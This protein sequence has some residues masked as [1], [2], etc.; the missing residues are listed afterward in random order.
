MKITAK[1]DKDRGSEVL[2]KKLLRNAKDLSKPLEKILAIGLSSTDKNFEA[3]GRPR[4]W[5]ELAESTKKQRAK[6]GKTGKILE[7][8]N[9]LKNSINGRVEGS[10]V[11]IGTVVPY[12]PVHQNGMLIKTKKATFFV[13][14]RQF[15][16]W[17]PSELKMA[18]DIL[19]KHLIDGLSKGGE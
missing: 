12:A 8:S 15:I 14:Q 19:T 6:I 2:F 11:K 16:K 7:R 10:S 4:K 18:E 5:K 13:P 17:Q 9:L 3:E 1:I